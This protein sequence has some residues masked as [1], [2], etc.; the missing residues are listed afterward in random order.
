M[1]GFV[2]RLDG[3]EV[4]GQDGRRDDG[5]VHVLRGRGEL[6]GTLGWVGDER[7]QVRVADAYRLSLD[8]E[9][10][11]EAVAFHR[12][13]FVVHSEHGRYGERLGAEDHG[14]VVSRLPVCVGHVGY[15]VA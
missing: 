15:V 12:R 5:V 14:A 8:R 9:V 7:F 11:E 2:K 10:D 3:V 1:Q 13:G 6:E 4:A